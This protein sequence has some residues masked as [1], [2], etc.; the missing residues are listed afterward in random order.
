MGAV[1]RF[2]N[3]VMY[4]YTNQ[5]TKAEVFMVNPKG[6]TWRAG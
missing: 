6:Q 1:S 3:C 2:T 4:M 5:G